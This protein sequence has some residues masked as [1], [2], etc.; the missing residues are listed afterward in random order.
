MEPHGRPGQ[1]GE[2]RGAFVNDVL[3]GFK[4][5]DLTSA[6]AGS[7]ATK[8]L[9][10]LGAEVTKIE[11]P[12]GG[13][14][15]RRLS[16]YIFHSF[17]RNKRSVTVDLK[18]P[19]GVELVRTI[20]ASSDVFIHSMRPGA[21]EDMG[22]GQEEVT[23]LNPRLIYASFSAFGPLGPGSGRRGVDAIA[24][25]ESG[26]V[27]MQDGVLGNL[28]YV[29]T[30]AGLALSQAV[31]A[32]LLHRERTGVVEHVE[33]NL[34]DAALYLQSGP[35]AA[36]SVTHEKVDVDEY[37]RR[38]PTIGVFP[39]AD[40]PFFQAPY[41]ECDWIALCDIIERP[42]VAFDERF[43][44]SDARR[45][46]AAELRE[47]LEDEF[48]RRPR[49]EWVEALEKWGVL[50]GEVH[51]YGE[52]LADEQVAANRSLEKVRLS[53]GDEAVIPRVPFRFSGR[54]LPDSR[55]APALGADTDAFLREL[56]WRDEELE[57]ARRRG[58][59]ASTVTE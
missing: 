12:A 3:Q 34:L 11:N 43:K 52:V 22:L 47:L 16:P 24:Q 54:E 10:D 44:D 46:H 36:F 56:G 6:L 32:A 18:Q 9:A 8:I 50:A 30:T 38:S 21:V 2:T 14:F 19:E 48:R 25:A 33:V 29:D 39:A 27:S 20:A 4:V 49:R 59:T 13:D 31:M 51:N 53:T 58:L 23:A 57:E 5:V 26:M 7:S 55:P 35:I 42:E 37:F 1:V 28:S 45:L 40:G 41:W 17:N 15:A